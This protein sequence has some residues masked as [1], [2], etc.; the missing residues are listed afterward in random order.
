MGKQHWQDGRSRYWL[1]RDRSGTNMKVAI[2]MNE[3][4]EGP[5]TLVALDPD[6]NKCHDKIKLKTDYTV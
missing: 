4:Y 5:F 6:T 1:G 2:R 3:D